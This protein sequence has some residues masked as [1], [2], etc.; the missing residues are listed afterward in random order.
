MHWAAALALFAGAAVAAPALAETVDRVVASIGSEA[1]TLSDL[2]AEYH[3][4]LFLD[5]RF[6]EGTPDRGSLLRIRDRLVE[7]KLLAEEAQAQQ[8]AIP[9]ASGEAAGILAE[10]QRKFASEE[11]YQSARRVL[12]MDERE[13]LV[14]IE[15]QQNTLRMIEQRFRPAAWPE[16]S[17][18]EAYY[19][20]TFVPEFARPSRQQAPPLAEVESQ[21]REILVQRKIDQLLSAWLEEL[22]STRR[23]RLHPLESNPEGLGAKRP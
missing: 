4:E 8:A 20:E 16:H 6:P 15:R 21:I 1:I 12:G 18:I 13:I 22:K 14:R 2:E 10:V 11:A 3:F 17:E 7:Q 19:R 9:P 23:V 5:G